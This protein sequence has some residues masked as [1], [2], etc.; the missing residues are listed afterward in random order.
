M[1][2]F[3]LKINRRA[4][5]L[6]STIIFACTVLM[7]PLS[8]QETNTSRYTPPAFA[9]GGNLNEIERVNLYNGNLN[10]TIPLLNIGGRGAA[11]YSMK[12]P[13]EHRWQVN[14]YDDQIGN[15]HYNAHYDWWNEIKPGYGAGVV[16][17][18]Q[19][20]GECSDIWQIVETDTNLTFTAPDGSEIEFRDTHTNGE[21]LMSSCAG[22][23]GQSRGTVFKSVDG[24]HMTFISD[25]TVYDRMLASS[26]EI[27]TPS[28]YL[29]FKDGTRYRI[30]VGKVSWIS[31][32]NGN[33]ATFTYA[34]YDQEMTVTDSLGR[35]T[36]V[37]Y[38]IND[39]APYGL[40]DKITF[41]G[42]NG[43]E[44][45]IRVS[46][47]TLADALKPGEV[48]STPM[49][50]NMH[51]T[52]FPMG[53]VSAWVVS[54]VWLP[55]GRRYR[56]LYNA[57]GEVAKLTL[58]TGAVIEYDWWGTDTNNTIYRRLIERRVYPDGTTLEGKTTYDVP[59]SAGNS[60]PIVVRNKTA[61]GTQLSVQKHYFHGDAWVESAPPYPPSPPLPPPYTNGREYET[62]FYEADG[63]TLLQTTTQTWDQDQ[64]PSGCATC[65]V[66]N[67][68]VSETTLTLAATS[69]VSKTTFSYDGFT[70][71][72][73]TYE[74]DYGTGAPGAFLRRTHTDY[75]TDTNYT[76]QTGSHIR[77]LP[78]QMWVSSDSAG[79]NRKSLTVY[80]YD[81][82][83]SNSTHAALEPRSSVVGHDTTNYGTSFSRRGNP[84][85]GTSYADAATQTGAVTSYLQY[86]ILGNVIKTIDANGNASTIQYA[87]NFGSPD[88]NAT[89]NT[90]PSQ[91]SGNNTFAF[92]TS[93][94]K[95]LGG[96]PWTAY[97]QYDYFT[98]QTVNTQDVNGM[99]GKALYGDVLDRPTQSFSAVGTSL[100]A[101]TTIAY[102]DTNRKVTKTS[103]LNALNDNLLKSESYYDGLGRTTETR[104]YE[105]ATVYRAV[106]T[107]YDAL[108][109]AH[110]TSNPFRSGDTLLWT[111]TYFDALGRVTK[112][113]T[114]DNAE[115]LTSYSGNA[116]TVTDQAG[117]LRRSITNALGQ[118]I[119]VDEPN[120][121]N[122]LGT[123]SS[124]NQATHYYYNTLGKMVDVHQG[125]QHR[126]FMYDSLGRMLRVKQP[127]Q[128]VNVSLN[129]SGN[130]DN[131]SWSGGFTYDNN[132]NVLTTTD[133]KGTT[134]TMT[135]DALDRVTQRS[136]NDNP[137]TATVNFYYDGAGLPS[138]PDFS[139]GKLTKVSSSVSESKY[140]EFDAV[141]RLKQF[142]QYTDGQT[143]TSKYTYNLSGALIEEEYPSGRKVKNEFDP[144][145]DL[146]KVTSQK[147]S[148]SVYIPYASTFSYSAAGAV[149]SMKLANG[150]WETAKFNA[151]LQ[152]AELGL[153]SSATDTGLWKVNYEYGEL[154]TNGSVDTTKNNGNIGK[155]TL[156][157]PGTDFV[158]GYKYDPLSRLTEAKETTG[159][160]QNWIQLFGYD[161]Y[162]NR[163]SFS[164]TI[165]AT[166]VNTTPSINASTNRF[167]T[168]QGF[169]YDA[170]GNI[171]QDVDP[172]T[173]HTRAFTFNGDNKQTQVKDVTD[174]NHVVGT[175]YYDGEGRRVKKVTDTETTVFVYSS[176]KLVAEYSTQLS[177]SPSVNYTTADHLGSPRILTDEFAQVKSRRDFMPFGQELGANVGGRTTALKYGSGD[178]VRQK[179]TG[180]QKDTETNL[181]FGEA[182]MYENCLGRFTAI[183][184]FLASGSPEVPQS[185]NRFV[186]SLN[187]P[188]QFSDPTG[189]VPE[190]V[191]K[192]GEVFFDSRV[193]DQKSA[194]EIY[195][196]GA[197]YK[198]NGSEYVSSTGTK[199]ELGDLGF[200]KEDG[201]IK[202]NGDRA[203]N[204]V[205]NRPTD[206]S[207]PIMMGGLAVGAVL[208]ADDITGIGVA[209]DPLIPIVIGGTALTALVAKAVQEISKIEEKPPG[210]QGV[211]YSLRATTAGAYTCYL[212]PTGGMNLK[213]GDIW[214]YGETT[215][216]GRYTQSQL[217]TIAGRPVRQVN[218]FAGN[219][220]QIKIAEKVK[221]YAYFTTHG[222]LPPGNKI[223]R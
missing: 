106:Q 199:V 171:T 151:R 17:A 220:V 62:R 147:N 94:T 73:D 47:S 158:Q 218:E 141:G 102:D 61:S 207:G 7:Q 192:D 124:P 129:T 11:G 24:S 126:Y 33:R 122:Q 204:A 148:S 46:K 198:P 5:S 110:K 6:M 208:A 20:R 30:D 186:Y 71:L 58:P 97:A 219:Q 48:S 37:Q 121:S 185:F 64:A 81:N 175:Y 69:Q 130:P 26:M 217:N 15:Y 166:T 162:G 117:K 155:Q 35:Q 201:V 142:Q 50:P 49:F 189:M 206:Y 52:S 92:A 101:Q 55:D 44:R 72:T 34:N 194:T 93:T 39:G 179:F 89:T 164:Q 203:E 156:T 83:A 90:A 221:I 57:Y 202:T 65:Y 135:Y 19:P 103:D 45:I 133:A 85:A 112:V 210:P 177:T 78:S 115:A 152:T 145:G 16:Q 66:N 68:R 77:A 27:L 200:F 188:L 87:D 42:T 184:P 165:G 75:V 40:C 163:T 3:N 146:A 36:F 181:D 14:V 183:D 167:N 144:S 29:Y 108:G 25:T 154:Q 100:E 38:G 195:G 118:L 191:Y 212:C 2:M 80:E 153:G 128:E 96:T 174:N 193:N 216:S 197:K 98:G 13:I 22:Q 86:D 137:Q 41:K 176:G 82:Y 157:I 159:T 31:D 161:V 119:R 182:R 10:H 169:S 196:E 149:I 63:T 43:A 105:D 8:A 111:Q 127:E 18:R 131:N 211:Q 53:S 213:P 1:I 104:S 56:F 178:N 70:N 190:W 76:S 54:S 59:S 88:G 134:T 170:N 214:K 116:V 114:P 113:K 168:G 140:V 143:Y 74:Y 79:N 173:A 12:L 60:N 107:Q 132:G 136:Y 95:L 21:P 222:Y 9:P 32:R 172:I 215:D 99:I 67:P 150:R 223:F 84:T 209:D 138:V 160:T 51:P 109:R 123:V 205:E 28:G 120:S 180:Y 91:L 4:T 23:Y 125:S 187:S 139:K